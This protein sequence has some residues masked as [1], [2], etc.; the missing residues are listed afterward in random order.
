MVIPNLFQAPGFNTREVQNLFSALN[1]PYTIRADAIQ[2]VGAP[3]SIAIL[4]KAIYWLYLAVRTF[5]KKQS[6]A[7]PMLP[8]VSED[9]DF[10]SS[11]EEEKKEEMVAERPQSMWNEVLGTVLLKGKLSFVRSEESLD[12]EQ[13]LIE[14]PSFSSADVADCA[15]VELLC[16]EYQEYLHTAA[17]LSK[18]NHALRLDKHVAIFQSMVSD[19]ISEK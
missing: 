19:T 15:L 9:I 5:F 8:I 17:P 13:H 1:Y 6:L 7:A 3:S 14:M 16:H 18:S 2:A 10:D 4:M 12:A 11:I